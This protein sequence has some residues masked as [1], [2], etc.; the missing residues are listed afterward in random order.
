MPTLPVSPYARR[1]W[2]E[3]DA[4]AVLAALDRSGKTLAAFCAERGLDAQRMYYWRRRLA[5]GEGTT[6]QELIVRPVHDR[7]PGGDEE[8]FEI[9]L[10]SGES[11]RVPARFEAA[12]LARLLEVLSKAR[13]C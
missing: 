10:P 9:Q 11:I 4:R 8:P 3:R 2:T 5:G 13:A 7:S 1:R 12:A 6:F